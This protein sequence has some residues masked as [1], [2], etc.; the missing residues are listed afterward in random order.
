MAKAAAKREALPSDVF[1]HVIDTLAIRNLEGLQ[2]TQ[3]VDGH[4]IINLIMVE[5]WQ[6]PITLYLQGHPIA[7][8]PKG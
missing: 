1:Y 8:R 2:I 6:A 7:K 3:D 5:D 4:R